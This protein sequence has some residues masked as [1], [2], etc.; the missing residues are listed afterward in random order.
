MHG[1]R[2]PVDD[3]ARLLVAR[4]ARH[5]IARS[6]PPVTLLASRCLPTTPRAGCC[7]PWS[8][9]QDRRAVSRAPRPQESR[10]IGC[11]GP[12]ASQRPAVP[13]LASRWNTGP[14]RT[15]CGALG[16]LHGPAK[17]CSCP[18]ADGPRGLA[19][20]PPLEPA[21]GPPCC[22]SRPDGP[23][24]PRARAAAILEPSTAPR[25]HCGCLSSGPPTGPSC[26]T[27]THAGH[28][29]CR[30]QL[31]IASRV[32]C[33]VACSPSWPGRRV[34]SAAEASARACY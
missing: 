17:P 30:A 20:R 25:S 9:P 1:P 7:P 15:G 19:S 22:F 28:P 24:P 14:R 11:G 12:G 21:R 3:E 2:R 31:E 32:P 23:S 27:P 34:V 5:L 8:P 26:C 16:A 6:T 13:F 18:R 4:G 33:S 10:G 29:P